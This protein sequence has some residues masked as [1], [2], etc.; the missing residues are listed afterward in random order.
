M[1]TRWTEAALHRLHGELLLAQRTA[2]TNEAEACFSRA[3]AVAREQGA[4]M[5]ELRAATSLARL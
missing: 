1:G 3:L 4:K 2:E 5:W